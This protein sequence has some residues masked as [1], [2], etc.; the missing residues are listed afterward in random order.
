MKKKKSVLFIL[1]I[2]NLLPIMYIMLWLIL[3]YFNEIFYFNGN[4]LKIYNKLLILFIYY[5]DKYIFIFDS[6]ILLAYGVF[7]YS[8]SVNNKFKKLFMIL[9]IA[10]FNIFV[11]FLIYITY[12]LLISV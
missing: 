2:L 11:D 12:C 10:M 6:V 9:C 1:F 8:K 3:L 5:A 7:V 4:V